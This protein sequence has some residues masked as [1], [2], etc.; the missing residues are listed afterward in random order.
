MQ[1]AI[2]NCT[3]PVANYSK[4]GIFIHLGKYYQF[5]CTRS[6]GSGAGDR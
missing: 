5:F 3:L 2:A 6:A 1:Q 4:Y